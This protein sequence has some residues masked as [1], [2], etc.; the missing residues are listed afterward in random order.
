MDVKKMKRSQM[1]QIKMSE[2]KQFKYVEVPIK[3]LFDQLAYVDK[4]NVISERYQLLDAGTRYVIVHQSVHAF[5]GASESYKG[6]SRID[7]AWKY[8]ESLGF[9]INSNRTETEIEGT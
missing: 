6:F 8:L 2:N 7:E 3:I 5:H 9:D 4:G 1:T